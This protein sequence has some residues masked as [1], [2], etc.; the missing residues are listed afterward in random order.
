MFSLKRSVCSSRTATTFGWAP[1]TVSTGWIRERCN[2]PNGATIPMK[3]LAQPEE[4]AR[5]VVF[6]AS[7]DASYITGEIVHVDA[8]YTAR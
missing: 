7:D 2:S 8:G 4:I 5:V 6:L 3:R 1:N